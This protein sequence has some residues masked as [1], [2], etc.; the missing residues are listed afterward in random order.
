MRLSTHD[1]GLNEAFGEQVG[2]SGLESRI[3]NPAD[4][5]RSGSRSSRWHLPTCVGRL[6]N[7]G[8][9]HNRGE[10]AE[11]GQKAAEK[12]SMETQGSKRIL[13]NS[14]SGPNLHRR[15]AAKSSYVTTTEPPAH[16]LAQE[17]EAS[18]QRARSQWPKPKVVPGSPRVAGRHLMRSKASLMAA[19]V[20]I[21]APANASTNSRP[22]SSPAATVIGK[23]VAPSGRAARRSSSR[24]F[25]SD[26][27][28]T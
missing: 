9:T 28:S 11:K 19:R 17:D 26:Q 12:G 1:E 13:P 16:P 15:P 7:G 25:F 22:M 6:D 20:R 3:I 14:F 5:S 18:L 24:S 27:A 2:G 23:M 8:M 10:A 21:S 4:S